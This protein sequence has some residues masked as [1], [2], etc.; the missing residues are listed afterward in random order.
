[1]AHAEAEGAGHVHVS[2]TRFNA[3]VLGG[4]LVLTGLTYW[5]ATLDLGFLDTPVALIIAF[6]KTT[7]VIL[8]FMHVRWA[9]GYVGLLAASGFVFLVLLFG[10][11]FADIVT[12]SRELPW[13]EYTWPGAAHRTGLVGD[14][15]QPPKGVEGVVPDIAEP[16]SGHEQDH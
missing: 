12:R 1:M 13:N 5:T 8:F 4:L 2:S 15:P 16:E 10:F 6:T 9:S 3:L 7:L 14:R 11:T